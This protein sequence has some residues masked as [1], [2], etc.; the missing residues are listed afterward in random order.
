MLGYYKKGD[1]III[2]ARWKCVCLTNK[3]EVGNIYFLTDR[4]GE[5]FEG[6]GPTHSAFHL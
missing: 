5:R 2:L 4:G 6:N 3:S 1:Y